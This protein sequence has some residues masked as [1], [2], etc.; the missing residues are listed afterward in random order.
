ML[1]WV[2]LPPQDAASARLT[3]AMS[4]I[5]CQSISKTYGTRLL[6]DNVSLTIADGERIG[7]IGPNGAGKTTLM[8]ILAGVDT[9]DS[10]AVSYRKLLRLGFVPQEQVFATDDTVRSVC[11]SALAG[12]ALDELEREGRINV[13]A[14]RTGFVDL[15]Q[16][17]MSLSG[18]WRKRLAIARELLRDP[19]VLLLDEPTN[20]LD[21]DGIIWLERL[22]AEARLASVVVSH[23]RYFLENYATDMAE[24]NRIYP[25]GLFRV[26]GGYSE[27]LLKRGEFR[28]A[29]AQ[30]RDSLQNQVRRE[31]EWLRRGPKARTTKSKAR[32]DS[33]GRM[34]QELGTLQTAAAESSVQINFSASGRKTKKLVTA[35]G[36]AKSLAGRALFERLDFALAPGVRLGLV[37]PNGSGKTTLLRIISGAMDVDAGVIERADGLR[38]VYFDQHREQL[39]PELPL[40]KALC[41]QGD[42]VIF[43]DKPIHVAGW[44]KRFLF[45]SEQL[46]LAVSQLS[47]GERARVAIA[48]LMLQPADLL[49]LD[50]PT[51][52]LDIAT[53][54]VLEENLLGFSGAMVLVTHDRY[55]LDR[56]ST[57]VLGLGLAT[58]MYAD[59]S[60]WELARQD[61][62]R[63]RSAKPGPAAAKRQEAP[64]KKR[65]SYM[66]AR[67]WET[68]ED[69]I[70]Q[71]EREVA[72]QHEQMQKPEI[73]RD[74]ARLKETYERLQSVESE[75][76][77]L[78]QRWAELEQ[79][80]H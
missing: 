1:H 67:E 77:R 66:E 30:Y 38:T 46:E 16:S 14:G 65:L 35:K 43:R 73:T 9:P 49:L 68:I 59:Y 75:V 74:P 36:I 37:G 29:Q 34:I 41:P 12:S 3:F 23:D 60:Q 31:V 15:T 79:K 13:I 52:D 61:E 8:Q 76:E 48:R 28:E 5:S 26:R 50:E 25:E 2:Y 32:I 39:D 18:G 58:G 24:I 17:A 20:H 54:E 70:H 64:Q 56:V 42:S 71:A 40:R 45:R 27:F 21:L 4:L 62:G 11:E 57:S 44:A 19:D 53:L 51:N 69:R 33:A 63:S 22:L 72:L 7:L 55:M 47:G 80:Q 6:F 78:Y 10:G